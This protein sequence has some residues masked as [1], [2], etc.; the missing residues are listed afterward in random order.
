[1]SDQTHGFLLGQI[2]DLS[3]EGVVIQPV[4]PGSKPIT[5]DY[6]RVYPAEE[7]DA[8]DVDDNCE[9]ITLFFIAPRF[10]AYQYN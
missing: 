9:Y 4:A 3:S 2:T 8:K 7:D 5:A 1:M 6:D 10:K